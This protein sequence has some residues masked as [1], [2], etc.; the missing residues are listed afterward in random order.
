MKWYK[1]LLLLPLLPIIGVDLSDPE[2]WIE[3]ERRKCIEDKKRDKEMKEIERARR[4]KVK[5]RH[6]HPY[7]EVYE[8]L[9]YPEK[10]TRYISTKEPGNTN[11]LNDCAVTTTALSASSKESLR[12]LK[13]KAIRNNLDLYKLV[14]ERWFHVPYSKVTPRQR[15]LAKA[16][17]YSF[18]SIESEGTCP[19]KIQRNTP[20]KAEPKIANNTVIQGKHIKIN[21]K[22]VGQP[23]DKMIEC[24]K[25]IC[26]EFPMK[27]DLEEHCEEMWYDYNLASKFIGANI[28][29]AKEKQYARWQKEKARS[30]DR[31][32]FSSITDE[33][34]YLQGYDASFFY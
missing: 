18:F 28:D 12:S 15:E 17:C 22:G 16:F 9:G 6:G 4:T 24:M 33:D 3:N 14:A 7:N 23:T 11:L 13:E 1:K 27:Q 32:G 5:D 8:C 10:E 31:R 34:C 30:F 26:S 20:N 19:D 21:F 2:R 29:N 25:W